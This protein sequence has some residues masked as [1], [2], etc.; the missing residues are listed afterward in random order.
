[1][2]SA[3]VRAALAAGPAM[4]QSVWSGPGTDWNTGANWGPAGVPGPSD[5]AQFQANGAPAGLSTSASTQVGAIGFVADA[6][7]YTLTLGNDFTLNGAG[8]TNGSGV[9]QTIATGGNVTIFQGGA[10]GSLVTYDLT[11]GGTVQFGNG[12]AGGDAAYLLGASG[13]IALNGSAGR[14]TLGLLTGD[15]G[16]EVVNLNPGAATIAIG[17]LN[18]DTIFAGA[19]AAGSAGALSLEKLGTGTLSL[20]GANDYTGTTTIS[21]GTLEIAGS[22]TLGAGA[23]VNNGVLAFN[24]FGLTVTNAISGTGAVRQDN[25]F[26]LLLGPL[27]Y[28]GGTTINGGAL[29]LGAPGFGVTLPGDAT[30]ASTGGL[31]VISGSLGRGTI[32]NEGILVLSSSDTTSTA[33]SATINNLGSGTIFF[34]DNASAGAARIDNHSFI[35]FSS[36]ATAGDAT[37][38]NDCCI[39]FGGDSTAGNATI[40]NTANGSIL[41]AENA[42]AGNSTIRNAGTLAFAD[43]SSG[44]M[45]RY[46]GQ[47]GGVLLLGIDAAGITLGSIE[48]TGDIAL[49]T[50]VLTVGGNNLSTNFAGLISDGGAGGGLVKTG[51]GILTLSG[52]NTYSGGTAINGGAISVA[53][54][55]ALGAA[56]GG[57]SLNGGTLVA[58]Q[59]FATARSV[60][61]EAAGGGFAPTAGVTLI[62]NGPV[63]GPGGLSVTGAGTLVLNSPASYAGP[64]SIASGSLVVGAGG[65][66]GA[67]ALNVASGALLD[68]SPMAAAGPRVASLS[69]GGTVALGSRQMAI[70]AGGGTFS[71]TIADGGQ[72]GGTGASVLI[73]GGT[74]V[75]TGTNTYTGTTTIQAGTLQIGAGGAGGTL[76]GGK[77]V[78]NGALVFNR[79]DAATV[80]NAISGTGSL[81]QNG[82]GN[83]ILT[84]TSSYTG[85]TLVNAGTLSVNGSIADSSGVT[86]ANGATLGGNGLLPGV[87]VVSGGTIAPGNSIGTL[88]V[89]GNLILAAGSTTVIELS[90]TAADRINVTGTATLGGTLRLVPTAGIYQ[91]YTNYTLIQAGAVTGQF[92]AVSTQGIFGAGVAGTVTTAGGQVRLGLSPV[93]LA[94]GPTPAIPGS[95]TYN[96]RAT[97]GALDSANRAGGNLS[98]FF[99]VYNQPASTIGVAVNQLSGEVATAASAMGFAA[100][101]Q[102]LATMLDPLGYGRESLMGGRLRPASGDGADV[103]PNA[104]RYAV[105]GSATGAYNRTTGDAADGSAS[106]TTRTSGFALGF[107]HLIGAQSMAGL[108]VAVGES[109][110]SVAGGQGNSRAN[111]GQIGTYGSTRIGSVTLAGAGAFTFMDVDTRRTLY[112][113]GNDRQTGGAG[114]QVYSLRAEA[115]QDGVTA[116]AFRFQPVAALQWQQVNN[117]GYVERSYVTGSTNSLT[118]PGQGNG[119]FR[120]E[121]GAQAQG[122]VQL[123]TQAVQG[124]ARVAWAHYFLR[125][126][127]MGVG[128]ASLPAAGFTVRGARPDADS[129]LVSA[130]LETQL[131]AGLTLGARVDSEFSGNVRQVA[132]TARLR[133][134]F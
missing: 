67:G 39:L 110:A 18:A 88:N 125:D 7:A 14:V 87:I 37:I 43:A 21:G 36:N 80:A 13:R 98:P 33:G 108:A 27:S 97:A 77:V 76:G 114:A 107:D 69:G 40:I 23:V 112:V 130:G 28:T 111:F 109:S 89:A 118:V 30:I 66:L 10:S 123:G 51:T 31:F 65:T 73:A 132:G 56:S 105:W 75:F 129:A 25:G 122:S 57:L 6:P 78:N 53:T 29:V 71:G 81:A 128:F 101:E 46:I 124:Y 44:G 38:R 102:F 8:V 15:A 60:T 119:S 59:S 16:S 52:V 12:S 83:L 113:L 64:T 103:V 2:F 68:A 1:M 50:K 19:I 92:A 96:L 82:A 58:T 120:S 5:T 9:N 127:S 121:L 32:T 47:A 126:A 74:T 4:A 42:S 79:S 49:G 85:P 134:R 48:G 3:L 62:L 72:D 84:G 91:F 90:P 22:G 20:T 106:R 35:L 131:M 95:L 11:A 70:T 61:L 86:V 54:D 133:Y 104:K 55:S 100:G 116:G 63:G 115:R 94:G 26:T 34:A 93:L 41:F 99:N 17:S 24:T 45:A 117:Q